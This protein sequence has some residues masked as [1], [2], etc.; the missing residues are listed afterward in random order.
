[1]FLGFNVVQLYR[2]GLVELRMSL[3]WNVRVTVVTENF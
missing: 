2:M 1:V 3:N